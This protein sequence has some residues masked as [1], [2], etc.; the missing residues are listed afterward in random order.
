M[1][2][3][4][5]EKLFRLTP[6]GRADSQI[7]KYLEDELQQNDFERY[8]NALK[9]YRNLKTVQITVKALF[10]TSIITSIAASFSL[11]LS[12]ISQIA[13]YLGSTLL[14]IIYAATSYLTMLYREEYHVQRDILIS[15]ASRKSNR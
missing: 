11:D 10:Y 4:V 14:L 5:I 12:I 6:L 1:N 9:R 15:D 13:S 8:N 7:K 3:T 2:Y